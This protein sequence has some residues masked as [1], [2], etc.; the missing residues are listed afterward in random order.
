[1]NTYLKYCPNVFVA[2]CEEQHEKGEE[3]ILTTKYGKENICVVWRQTPGCGMDRYF[4][5]AE[6]AAIAG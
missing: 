2:K 6:F 3:I 5:E 1:M 4:K